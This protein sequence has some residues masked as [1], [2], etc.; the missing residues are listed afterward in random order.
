VLAL[1]SVVVVATTVPLHCFAAD[2]AARR[3]HCLPPPLLFTTG[4]DGVYLHPICIIFGGMLEASMKEDEQGAHV[5]FW[6]PWRCMLGVE[7]EW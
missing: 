5:E 1:F 6:F 2:V 3:H 7:N 4:L